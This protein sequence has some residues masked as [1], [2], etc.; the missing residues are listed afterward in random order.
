MSVLGAVQIRSKLSASLS[1]CS[2]RLTSSAL[3]C[4]YCNSP[5]AASASRASTRCHETCLVKVGAAL[6]TGRHK[7]GRQAHL[8][9]CANASYLRLL[10]NLFGGG[11][12]CL[13]PRL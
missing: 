2:L 10:R 4:S 9:D 11:F 8:A 5:G 13:R 6:A 7:R 3:G 1:L 12:G